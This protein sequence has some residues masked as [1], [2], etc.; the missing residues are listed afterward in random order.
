MTR[1][2]HLVLLLALL[3]LPACAQRDEPLTPFT[4][5]TWP[6]DAG[7]YLET[8]QGECYLGPAGH[9]LSL[10]LAQ[11][12]SAMVFRL[13]HAGCRPM[14]VQVTRYRIEHDGQY[15]PTTDPPLHMDALNPAWY[16]W[17]VAREHPVLT[18]LV[19][20]ALIVAGGLLTL[21]L[22]QNRRRLRRASMIDSMVLTRD[23][24]L[25]ATLLG[26]SIGG[27]KLLSLLGRGGMASV[28]RACR[29]EDMDR[30]EPEEV[31]L[32][33]MR[34]EVTSNPELK[35]RFEREIRVC[36][37]LDH[38]GIVRILDHG[39]EEGLPYLVMELVVGETLRTL[40]AEKG[41]YS[42][43]E[44]LQL[45]LPVMRA[46]QYAHDRGVVHRDLKP[47]NI[48]ILDS[49]RAVK[50]MDFGLVQVEGTRMTET[51]TSLGTPAYMSPEQ[52][53]APRIDGRSDQYSL[54]VTA[55]EMLTGRPPFDDEVAINILFKH[56]QE[57]V[58]PV[59][60]LRPDCPAE[61][62]AVI[63]R[64][65]MKDPNDRFPSLKEAAEALRS[66]PHAR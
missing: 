49:N 43:D 64:M 55:Y 14:E 11:S 37:L 46:V 58:A 10:N 32:K 2:W 48:M 9:V 25:D 52:I 59:R 4:F 51:G 20:L 34:A 6:A 29:D 21:W 3:L 38:P 47:E 15:P 7:V 53:T 35:K 5:R 66:I 65:L 42:I 28:Y 31:A 60:E 19:V 1:A 27:Y 12:G 30:P 16:L 50:V 62:E 17:L 36:R 26:K 23:T 40:L 39:E 22:R 24:L 56:L 41:R 45:L 63:M 61:L 57:N 13:R 8:S 44:T 33:L 18:V 54:G